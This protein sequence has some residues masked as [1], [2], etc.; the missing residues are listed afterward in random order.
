MPFVFIEKHTFL[1]SSLVSLSFSTHTK[2][3]SFFPGGI[4]S[5]QSS[6]FCKQWNQQSVHLPPGLVQENLQFC[7]HYFSK[8]NNKNYSRKN[9]GAVVSCE[10]QGHMQKFN[11]FRANKKRPKKSLTTFMHAHHQLYCSCPIKIR[12]E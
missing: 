2:K 4:L 10:V 3:R 8:T 7:M 11:S 5:K 9:Y 1:F 6:C 12:N